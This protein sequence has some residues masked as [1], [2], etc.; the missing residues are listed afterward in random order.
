MLPV[1][2]R[3]MHCVILCNSFE[4]LSWLRYADVIESAGR[5]GKCE[6]ALELYDWVVSEAAV[7]QKQKEH[8]EPD[9]T[10]AG[11]PPELY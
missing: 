1:F 2:Y 4:F 7:R 10:S 9:A 6:Q 8:T 11:K 5:G 3:V